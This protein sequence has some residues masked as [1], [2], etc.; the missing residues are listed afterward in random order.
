MMK[1]K[2]IQILYFGLKGACIGLISSALVKWGKTTP[3]KEGIFIS[4]SLL[5]VIALQVTWNIRK[6][7]AANTD[8]QKPERLSI[9]WMGVI[10]GVVVLSLLLSMID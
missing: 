2:P 8:N 10:F 9:L 4:L 6:N 5:C 1:T 3:G 7:E